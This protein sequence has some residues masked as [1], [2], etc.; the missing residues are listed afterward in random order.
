MA[1]MLQ[2]KPL[3]MG[4]NTAQMLRMVVQF[5][6][7][8]SEADLTFVTNRKVRG[9]R[10]ASITL[11]TSRVGARGRALEWGEFYRIF[12]FVGSGDETQ[13][14]GSERM[15]LDVRPK[16]A[17]LSF[18]YSLKARNRARYEGRILF[19]TKQSRI[20]SETWPFTFDDL[21]VCISEVFHFQP[22]SL[23]HC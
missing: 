10:R 5:M 18:V 3:F 14:K 17:P 1:E 11:Q 9:P 6:G 23:R 7:K 20:K 12:D 21:V 22:S 8:P 4:S 16:N 13:E 19:E 2:R 15:G